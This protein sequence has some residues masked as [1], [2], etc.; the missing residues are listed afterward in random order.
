MFTNIEYADMLLVMGE[1]HSNVAEAVRTYAN[2]R[3]G[4]FN[5]R[6]SHVYATENPHATILFHYQDRFSVN[7]W[8]GIQAIHLLGPS[9]TLNCT[10]TSPRSQT[11]PIEVERVLTSFGRR[12]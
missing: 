2:S 3:D 1:C 6:N 11:M 5:S 12:Q 7:V 4:F 9:L 10:G 8:A